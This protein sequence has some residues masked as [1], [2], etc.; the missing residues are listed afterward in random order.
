MVGAG[1]GD[2]GLITEN[3]KR[4]L[5]KCDAV[6]YDHLVS[7]EL[8]VPLNR[9]VERYYAGKSAGQHT[10]KQDKIEEL[11]VKL[12]K[13]GKNVVR[14]KG[15]DPYVFGRGGEEAICLRK[16]GIPFEVVPGITAGVAGPAC[17]G[18]P[19]THR[20]KAVFTIFLT[21]HEADDK[22]ESQIP[23]EL[24]G[25]AKHG[26]IVGYMG[27]KTLPNTVKNLIEQGMDPDTPAAL[28][29]KGT[30]G[31]RRTITGTLATIA[32][33][34]VRE[35]IKPPA[36]FVFGETVNLREEIG[37][38]DD[39]PLRGKTIMITRPGGQAGDMYR[40]LR[41]MGAEVLP[42]PSIATD[43][44][45]DFAGWERFWSVE[46]G[47][48]VFT[49]ENGVR[50]FFDYYFRA[51]FDIRSIGNFKIAAVGSGTEKSL[52][53]YGITADFMPKKYTVK[54][55]AEELV[56][57]YNFKD[58]DVVRVRG[59]LAD[60]TAESRLRSAG[61][62]ILP[63]AV[64]RTYTPAWD[65][66]MLAAF[67]DANIDAVTFTSGST[68]KRL[69]EILGDEEFGNFMSKVPAISIGP[70]TSQTVIDNGGK[71]AV[72]AKIHSIEGVMEA[73][74]EL[75]KV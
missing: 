44:A 75:F 4:A 40:E 8:V 41:E 54:D 58:I 36:L 73:I 63:L 74:R 45:V 67:R 26:T 21:A 37:E 52:K 18:I 53:G 33:L 48:L 61:A 19:V 23:W 69:K 6:V 24:L 2:P 14:L 59:N 12:A 60:D 32:D 70:M 28:V 72:E 29:E 7:L 55:L 68:V 43:A 31:V 71:V 47:W 35:I 27:V 5:E 46:N 11:L 51:G 50:Y 39:L 10:L 25:K 38:T 65:E 22:S 9:N 30:T 62:K 1:P 20:E 42:L 15:G 3:G 13:E 17:A 16:N 34:A 64:Y 56:L 49:S 66:G 57:N